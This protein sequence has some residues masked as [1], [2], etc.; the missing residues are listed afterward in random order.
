MSSALITLLLSL[1]LISLPAAASEM[2]VQAGVDPALAACI[3]QAESRWYPNTLGAL[4]EIGLMQIL[5]STGEWALS[6]LGMSADTDLWQPA[7]NLRVGMW[8]LAEYSSWFST[9]YLCE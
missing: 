1:R 4:G 2:S 8:I 5:P 7:N 6:K 9:L 3:I